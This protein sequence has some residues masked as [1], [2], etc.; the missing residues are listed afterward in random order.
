MYLCYNNGMKDLYIDELAKIVA[1]EKLGRPLFMPNEL[2]FLDYNKEIDQEWI[3]KAFSMYAKDG[4]NLWL[5]IYP[6]KEVPFLEEF[7][8]G[9][10]IKLQDLPSSPIKSKYIEFELSEQNINSFL[11]VRKNEF[12][13]TEIIYLNPGQM[14]FDK[15]PEFKQLITHLI[16]EGLT[17]DITHNHELYYQWDAKVENTSRGPHQVDID[18]SNGCTHNCQFCGLYA[19]SV[20]ERQKSENSGQLPEDVINIQKEKISVEKSNQL[21]SQLPTGLER[22]ILGGA[23]DPYTHGKINEVIRDLRMRGVTVQVFTNFAY[24]LNSDIDKLHDLCLDNKESLSFIANVSGATPETYLK[25][26]PNQNND[27][28]KKVT[29]S[30]KYATDLIKRDGKGLYITLMCVTTKDNYHEMPSM[31]A[32]SKSLGCDRV[33]IKPLEPHDEESFKILVTEEDSLDYALKA[34]QSLYLA[35]KLGVEIFERDILERIVNNFSE[36]IEQYEKNKSIIEQVKE[37]SSTC[38]WI[39]ECLTTP[40]LKPIRTYRVRYG[41]IFESAPHNKSPYELADWKLRLDQSHW[42][43]DLDNNEQNFSSDANFSMD[44]FDNQPCYIGF[45]YMRVHVD[46][47]TTPCCNLGLSIGDANKN[48]LE[49]IWKSE[50]MKEFREKMLKMNSEKFHR[51]EDIYS[52]CAQC[53]HLK[54]NRLYHQLKTRNS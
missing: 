10:V 43:E 2:V 45:N 32:M 4:K 5:K 35:D 46:G 13:E 51:K 6:D 53:P 39:L 48:S 40:E 18:L 28:F 19:D 50:E 52:V 9:Y 16:S 24:L 47:K 25:T 29:D 38:S 7:I 30:I 44:V 15:V 21:I 33:W 17:V 37:L 12:I 26:R 8:Q 20:I 3:K 41:H 34:K 36:N 27:T 31:I 23:G 11:K 42:K 54:F 1:Y 49:E 14:K 22:V